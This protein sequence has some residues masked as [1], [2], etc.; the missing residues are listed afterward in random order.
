ML[1]VGNVA[2]ETAAFS[3]ARD[4]PAFAV[5]ML[6]DRRFKKK[7]SALWLVSRALTGVPL[8]QRGFF[9]GAISEHADG[10]PPNGAPDLTKDDDA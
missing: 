10:E 3:R 5:G 9:F 4:T 2:D 6:R 1:A 7:R 8:R